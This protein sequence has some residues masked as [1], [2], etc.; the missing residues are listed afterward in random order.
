MGL[1]KPLANECC[2]V[3]CF[4]FQKI[5]I[6]KEK[7]I[8]IDTTNLILFISFGGLLVLLRVLR[9]TLPPYSPGEQRGELPLDWWRN[10]A[11]PGS[12]SQEVTGQARRGSN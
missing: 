12:H 10:Q 3:F 8:V 5:K 4:L 6:K 2:F 9:T 1:Y 7:E 11:C